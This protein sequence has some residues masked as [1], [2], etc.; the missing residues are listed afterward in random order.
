[1]C[2][3]KSYQGL[4]SNLRRAVTEM[5]SFVPCLNVRLRDACFAGPPFPVS[6]TSI[7]RATGLMGNRGELTEA[8]ASR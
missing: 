4:A 2:S 5:F 6:V 1:M 7:R 8:H 3:Y